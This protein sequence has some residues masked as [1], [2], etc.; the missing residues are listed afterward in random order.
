MGKKEK[1][2]LE[3]KQSQKTVDKMRGIHYLEKKGVIRIYDFKTGVA[4]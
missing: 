3:R 2:V 4:I 1:E